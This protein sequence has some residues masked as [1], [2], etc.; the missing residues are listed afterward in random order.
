MLWYRKNKN[1]CSI[2]HSFFLTAGTVTFALNDKLENGVDIVAIYYQLILI[3]VFAVI[4]N[5]R[6]LL[7]SFGMLVSLIAQGLYQSYTCNFST[8]VTI[9]LFV[10]MWISLTFITYFVEAK[11]KN[12]YIQLKSNETSQKRFRHML[13]VVPEGIFI[14]DPTKKS[15]LMVN[16]ELYRLLRK[17]ISQ[18]PPLVEMLKE[19]VIQHTLS[20]IEE[21]S[22]EAKS[23]RKLIN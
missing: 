10:L 19:S 1:I 2:L 17:H 3:M 22:P 4:I 13:E 9:P 20:M 15:T 14:F 6:W 21:A 5:N 23:Q 18:R 12:E 16:S 11:F 8:V 7:T